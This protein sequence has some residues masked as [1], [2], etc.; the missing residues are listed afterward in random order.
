LLD[1]KG[2]RSEGSDYDSQSAGGGG[3]FGRSSS[4]DRSGDERRPAPTG[5]GRLSNQLDDDIPF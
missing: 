2:G 1:S 4:M 3:S 5:G